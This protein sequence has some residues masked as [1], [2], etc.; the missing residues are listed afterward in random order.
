MATIPYRYDLREDG[1]KNELIKEPNAALKQ[2]CY[3]QS[4]ILLLDI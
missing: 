4:H 2:E 3:G 1:P